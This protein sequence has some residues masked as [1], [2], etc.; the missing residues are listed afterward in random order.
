VLHANPLK[1]REY[2]A[3]GKPVVTVSTP[4]IEQFRDYVTIASSPEEFLIGIERALAQDVESHK[5]RR[6]SAVADM[7]WDR[8]TEEVLAVVEQRLS[9]V[10]SASRR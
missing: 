2:L 6:I 1:L 5:I 9:E 4:V 8:R 3:T 7:S 10:I